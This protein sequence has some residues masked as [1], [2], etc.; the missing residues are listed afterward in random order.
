MSKL[1]VLFLHLRRL[2][3]E[4]IEMKSVKVMDESSGKEIRANRGFS[5]RTLLIGF[6]VVQLCVCTFLLGYIAYDNG[7][8]TVDAMGNDSSCWGNV[9]IKRQWD[10]S[11]YASH[12]LLHQGLAAIGV[13]PPTLGFCRQGSGSCRQ[14]SIQGNAHHIGKKYNELWNHNN[15]Q[16]SS[17]HLYANTLSWLWFFQTKWN[18]GKPMKL[19][20]RRR[21]A[22][23]AWFFPE[24]S[25]DP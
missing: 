24:C 3:L 18:R 7:R 13:S 16:C 22:I 20:R 8:Q 25:Y 12:S 2:S 14:C 15:T 5:L 23:A 10:Q 6:F 11:N 1:A 21:K 17:G 9:H 4:R 19:S